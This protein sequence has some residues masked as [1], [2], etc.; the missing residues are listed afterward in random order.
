M[1]IAVIQHAPLSPD[2]L[3]S[4]ALARVGLEAVLFQSGSASAEIQG[5]IVMDAVQAD[6]DSLLKKESEL[7]KP[8]LGI[9]KG[10]KALTAMGLVP[11]SEYYKVGIQFQPAEERQV[12]SLRL[13]KDYQYNA[14]TQS[15]PAKQLFHFSIQDNPGQF[16]IPPGLMME[17]QVQGLII[18]CYCDKEG[19]PETGPG[20]IAAIANKMG[21]VMAMIPHPEFTANGDSIFQSMRD[22]IQAGYVEH[23][24]PLY[25]FPRTQ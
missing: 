21:N 2:S 18:F 9:G 11:G 25:Y 6:V 19:K 22:Y 16:F 17:M 5:Y 1:Q 13:A 7:G 10:A 12:V 4:Q 20:S 14:F 24:L 23:V 3:L 8:I 15:I